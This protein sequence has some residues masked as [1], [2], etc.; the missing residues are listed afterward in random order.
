MKDKRDDIK[1]NYFLFI[2]LSLHCAEKGDIL[3][4]QLFDIVNKSVTS[5]AFRIIML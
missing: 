5:I 2:V 3:K 4:A 1:N